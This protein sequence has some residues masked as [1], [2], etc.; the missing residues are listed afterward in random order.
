MIFFL[1]D[2]SRTDRFA[3]ERDADGIRS[4]GFDFFGGI[5]GDHRDNIAHALLIDAGALTGV[6]QQHIHRLGGFADILLRTCN[7]DA[8][9]AVDDDDLKLLLNEVQV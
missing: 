4:Q 3:G 8:G 2:C 5:I 6:F 1:S 7:L 9:A